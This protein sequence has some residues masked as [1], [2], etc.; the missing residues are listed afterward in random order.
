[1]RT[2]LVVSILFLLLSTATFAQTDRNLLSGTYSKDDVERML[3]PREE[4]HPFPTIDDREGWE[5]V[6]QNVR[7]AHISLAESHLGEAWPVLPAT[8]F[9][10]YV[11]SGNRSNYEAISFERRNRLS[12]LV[13]GEVFENQGRFLD[14]IAD[15]VWAICE[16]TYWGVPAHMSMQK[17]GSGLPD[18]TE[19][20][21]DLFAAETASLL[22]WTV[23]LLG[24]SLDTV[25][26]LIR[27]RVFFEVDRKILAPN[28]ERDDFWWMGFG[29]Q[30]VNNWNPWVN[31]NWL[32]SALLM[33][34]SEERRIETVHKIF[35]S[36]DQFI[37]SYPEDGGCDEGPSYWG[38]AGA[39]LFDNLELLRSASGGS[40]DIYHESL[41]GEMA[42]YVY[43]AYIAD[44][45]FINYAD[46]SAQISPDAALVYAFGKRIGDETMQGFGK[47]LADRSQFGQGTV[48]SRLARQ[49][50]ALFLLNEINTASSTEP[51]VRDVWLPETQFLVARS[52]DGSRDGFYLG[53]KGGHNDESHNHNDIGNYVVYKDGRPVIIDVGAAVYNAKTFSERRYEIWNM[54]SGFHNLPSINGVDQMQGRQY[55]ARDVQYTS[56][57]RRANL[58]LELAGAYPEE[59]SLTSLK[60][61]IT[62]ERGREVIVKDTYRLEEWR[63]SFKTNLMT[64]LVPRL[65]QPGVIGLF[66][67]ATPDGQAPV[68]HIRFNRRQFEFTF[69]P[70]DVSDDTRMRSGWGDL[71]FRIVLT[72]HGQSRRGSYT[73]RITD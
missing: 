48:G 8:V 27:E 64:S 1:M 35:R 73:I 29:D 14:D 57:D 23:Y 18:V 5:A 66:T 53:A 40:I 67:S 13:L 2:R 72:S 49:L 28:L 69:E 9:L 20:T 15:G 25:H 54:Q 21:V 38:R 71:I 12:A 34:R 37:N 10:G 3:I 26:P 70:I 58:T 22:A 68:A 52:V 30:L 61:E 50:P 46:A 7:Q 55:A 56:N 32:A 44:R 16:E 17:L 65:L 47:M 43:R 41:I 60:R 24:D 36:L 45:Y 62:L 63:E 6:P 4:W 59:A 33:E 42:R 51:L 31:S 11:R 19:P 39:S